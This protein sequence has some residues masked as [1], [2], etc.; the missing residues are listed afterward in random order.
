METGP[1][2][3]VADW[4][5]RPESYPH[6]PATVEHIETHI[7]HV[8]LA[9]DLVYKLK[10]PVRFDFLDFSTIAARERACREKVRLN[11]RLAPDVYLGVVAVT[12]S[13]AAGFELDGDGEVVD[14]LVAM[15]R[16]PTEL[17]LDALFRRGE[18]TADHIQR[19][20]EVL[21]RFYRSLPP[22]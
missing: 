8:F 21:S 15:R 22:L 17:T 5:L 1:N 11:Q 3:S 6:R 9:G 19:L 14:W 13:A 4:L 7:S 12:R 20:A 2:K 18:L 10:K 16:L